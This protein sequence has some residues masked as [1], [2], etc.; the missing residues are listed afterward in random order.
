MI[1]GKSFDKQYFSSGTYKIYKY[2]EMLDEWVGPMAKRIAKTL[3]DRK[4]VKV[5]DVGCSFGNL[6]AEL[7]DKYGFEVKGLEYSA[8]AIKKALPTVR[9]KIKEGTILNPPFKK[10]SFDAVVCFDVV[11]HL[12]K[13]EVARAI[14]NLIVLSR[15]YIFFASIYRHSMWT[16]QKINPDKLRVTTL[17]QKEYID[18]FSA[19]GA[20]FVEKFYGGNGG[21]VLVF[22]KL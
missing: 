4:K 7:Q 3:K 10:N 18:I 15:H 16:S 11:C 17:S 5:L 8:Y 14:K 20:K 1:L 6:I 21:E 12:P 9:R 22:K 2:K 19:N 13:E